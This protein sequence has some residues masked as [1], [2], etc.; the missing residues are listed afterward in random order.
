MST[1]E[2][3][4][5]AHSPNLRQSD[6]RVLRESKQ[7]HKAFLGLQTVSLGWNEEGEVWGTHQ[8]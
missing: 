2:R 3:D 4:I 7:L 8:T 6:H 5:R 1:K